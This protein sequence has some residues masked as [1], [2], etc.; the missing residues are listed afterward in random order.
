MCYGRRFVTSRSATYNI[1]ISSIMFQIAKTH[2]YVRSGH[3]TLPS[4]T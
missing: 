2:Y 3:M 1:F 4:V